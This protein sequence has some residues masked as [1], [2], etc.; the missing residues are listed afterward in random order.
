M[1]TEDKDADTV[2]KQDKATKQTTNESVKILDPKDKTKSIAINKTSKKD[3]TLHTPSLK[4][5]TDQERTG[6]DNIQVSSIASANRDRVTDSDVAKAQKEIVDVRV[7]VESG[8]EEQTKN[9]KR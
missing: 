3:T 8:I 4:L 9:D 6:A 7:D 2:N 5:M 1:V